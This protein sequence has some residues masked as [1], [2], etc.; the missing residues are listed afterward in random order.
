MQKYLFKNIQLVNEGEIKTADILISGD[1]I[2]K[3]GA[4]IDTKSNVQE[5]N[6]EGKFLLP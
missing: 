6:G 5:I 4:K 2:E 1:R 3:I